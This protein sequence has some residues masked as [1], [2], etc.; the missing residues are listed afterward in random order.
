M[1]GY[2]IHYFEV[3]THLL[4][5]F[6]INGLQVL[7]MATPW[8]IEFNQDIFT[9]VIDNFIKRLSNNNLKELKDKNILVSDLLWLKLS[10][11]YWSKCKNKTCNKNYKRESFYKR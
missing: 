1:L 10:A 8:G 6:F 5:K 11:P 9:W 7:A 4:S 2:T 3:T